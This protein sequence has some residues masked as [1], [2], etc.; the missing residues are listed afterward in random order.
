MDDVKL[1]EMA[2]E[3]ALRAYCPYSH[4][5][6][7]AALLT[8]EGKVFCG[9]NVEN[10]SYGLTL[11]AER[12]ALCSAVAA[13]YRDFVSIAIVASRMATPCGACRQVLAEFVSPTFR[14]LVASLPEPADFEV[15]TMGALLPHHFMLQ[16]GQETCVPPDGH[17]SSRGLT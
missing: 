13:G 9:C 16:D 11:C 15:F 8:P 6:V 4:F 3:A 17:E 2:G 5:Q 10:A 14:V 12:T 7:G 1:I